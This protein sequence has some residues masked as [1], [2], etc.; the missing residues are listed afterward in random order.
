MTF[1]RAA[2][3]AATLLLALAVGGIA[4]AETPSATGATFTPRAALDLPSMMQLVARRSAAVQAEIL[5]RELASAEVR[6]SHLL[7]NPTVDATWGTIPLGETNPPHLGS[8]LTSVPSYG[9]GLAYTF[10]LGKRGPRQERAAAL[11]E[12]ARSG[13]TA[14]AR[15][16]A[17]DLARI[18]GTAA[19]AGLRVEGLGGL[20]AQ[21]RGSIALAES[22]LS[23]GFGTPLDVDRLR[24][25][26]NRTEQQV[27][28]NEGDYRDALTACASLLG[29][30]CE[31]FPSSDEAREFLVAWVKRAEGIDGRGAALETRPDVRALEAAGR[32]AIAEG[33]FASA[34]AL[35]DPTVRLGYVY[36]QFV[37]S[38]NQAHSLNLSL[39][40]PLPLFDH[41]QALRDAADA[42]RRRL[43]TQRERVLT[44]A[45]V[46]LT[47]L[48]DLLD[49]RERRQEV[50]VMQMLP[51]ARTVVSDLEKAAATRLIPLTDVIQA[52]RTLS[53]VL[54]QEAESYGD[55]FQ[56]AVNLVEESASGVADVDPRATRAGAP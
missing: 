55:A 4:R 43:G 52:R 30:R 39:Q 51:R 15:A 32:A 7:G 48:R 45:R 40:F 24:I 18:L 11:E 46:R 27:L 14:T 50:I 10:P 28:D 41:G 20:V 2:V 49:V 17:L 9:V 12:S 26:L 31:A 6:Q 53:E 35:P 29:Q 8:P 1:P 19:V 54:L 25:E 13:V 37:A 16:Q 3:H 33:S 42:R 5:N 34:Q 22:R 38:G 36:D 21:E 23:G 47:V 44:V 56:V